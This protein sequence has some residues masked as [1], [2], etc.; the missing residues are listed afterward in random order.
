MEGVRE[1]WC[2]G[3]QTWARARKQRLL[4]SEANRLACAV[5][6]LAVQSW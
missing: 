2:Q 6:T 4:A 5:E 3:T 1:F